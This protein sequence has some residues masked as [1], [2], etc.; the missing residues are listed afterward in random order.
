MA[1]S[2]RDGA[3]ACYSWST[4][5]QFPPSREASFSRFLLLGGVGLVRILP[6]ATCGRCEAA[7]EL[8]MPSAS[9]FPHLGVSE[10]VIRA[11]A[12]GGIRSP[13][14]IQTMVIP[15]ALAGH[16]VLARSRTGS[17]KT[18]AFAVPIVERIDPAAPQP[19]ALILVPTRELCSQVTEGFSTICRAKG[20][21]VAAVY[22]GVGMGPQASAAHARTCSW[23]HPADSRTSPTAG[24]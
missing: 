4:D 6:T 11:L 19:S 14:P 1:R 10:A 8:N 13:F 5:G 17:G 3:A 7:K 22:G 15:D 18:L 9:T 20:L 12:D 2:G 23:R 21:R 24:S 16:D